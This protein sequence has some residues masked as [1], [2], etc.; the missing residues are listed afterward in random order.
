MYAK[1]IGLLKQKIAEVQLDVNESTTNLSIAIETTPKPNEINYD[2]LDKSARE[3]LVRK[4]IQIKLIRDRIADL[5]STQ[6]KKLQDGPLLA[7]KDAQK[8]KQF[9]DNCS[10]LYRN[11]QVEHQTLNKLEAIHFSTAES[12]ADYEGTTASAEG[13]DDD[14]GVQ[15]AEN[16]QLLFDIMRSKLSAN[17][18][19]VTSQHLAVGQHCINMLLGTGKNMKEEDMSHHTCKLKRGGH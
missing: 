3:D 4:D 12:P 18:H 16:N 8:V 15:A 5:Q 13:Q 17:V 14:M 19:A 11:R 9:V 2:H 6:M 1:Q 10:K 7:I